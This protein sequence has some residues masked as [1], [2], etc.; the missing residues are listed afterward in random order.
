ME[1]LI[2][3]AAPA[4]AE[5]IAF[6]EKQTFSC[7]WSTQAV[8]SE[9]EKA[10]AVFLVCEVG[11]DIAGYVSMECIYGE[12]YVGNLA[13]KPRY[14]RNGL[15]AALLR[16]LITEAENR[17]GR[18]LTLEVRASNTAAIGLYEQAGFALQGVRRGFYT[19]PAE[20]GMIYT[21]FIK[22]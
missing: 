9:I 20:D 11:G 8:L 7:P 21:L 17:N 19:D 4:D 14:R 1:Y 5:A 3:S 10:Y 18:F 6:I 16:H 2:R 12:C 15:A 13:I 22:D